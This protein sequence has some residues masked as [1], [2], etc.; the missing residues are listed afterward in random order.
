MTV[1]ALDAVRGHR[2]RSR[3]V[4]ARTAAAATTAAPTT[5][6]TP[7]V[8]L[9]ASRTR[10]WRRIRGR[11]DGRRGSPAGRPRPSRFRRRL[12]RRRP[13]TVAASLRARVRRPRPLGLRRRI[14]VVRVHEP[15]SAAH[16]LRCELDD[17]VAA[18]GHVGPHDVV[19]RLA[20]R[21]RNRHTPGNWARPIAADE[22]AGVVSSTATAA[23]LRSSIGP[24]ERPRRV[25]VAGQQHGTAAGRGTV[26]QPLDEPIAARRGSRPTGRRASPGRRGSGSRSAPAAPSTPAASARAARSR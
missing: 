16:V 7:A 9:A 20:A 22:T 6:V 19:E 8:P 3:T 26:A 23:P 13:R 4:N 15:H 1:R 11:S 5:A 2:R 12:G 21:S 10:R 14:V 18:L 25:H 24:V 17:R